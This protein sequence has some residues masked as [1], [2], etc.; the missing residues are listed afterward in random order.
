MNKEIFEALGMNSYIDEYQNKI[1]PMCHKKVD[2][3][4]FV[5]EIERKEFKIS[6]MCKKCQDDFFGK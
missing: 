1:C 6:G 3:N 5:S 2:E 4:E